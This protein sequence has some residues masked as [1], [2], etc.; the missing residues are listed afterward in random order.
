[1]VD[2]FL[3]LPIDERERQA[4]GITAA[5]VEELVPLTDV[6]D[7][8]LCRRMDSTFTQLPAYYFR[9]SGLILGTNYVYPSTDRNEFARRVFV[10][11]SLGHRLPPYRIAYGPQDLRPATALGALVE[12][13]WTNIT[14]NLDT[15]RLQR[16]TGSGAFAYVG[17]S[18]NGGATGVA[19]TT[20]VAG[21][22][23]RYRLVSFRT[24]SDS[25]FSNEISV[26][27][28]DLGPVTRAITGLLFRDQFDRADGAP[29]A[30]W[31]AESG[32]WTIA[33]NAMQIDI[34]YFAS[35]VMRLASL[36]NRKDFHIQVMSSRSQLGNYAAVYARR[37]GGTLYLADLGASSEQGGKP[38]MYRQTNGG[39]TVLG[40]GTFVSS[41]NTMHRL[42]FSVLGSEQKLWADGALQVSVTD[43]AAANDI[44]G[45]LSFHAYGSGTAGTVR[46]DDLI[47]NASRS[48]TIGGLPVGHRL[49][50]AGLLS[51]RA[52]SGNDVALDLMGIQLP[53]ARIEV[54]D[55][56]DVMVKIFA[57]ADG[58]W[59]G[60]RYSLNGAP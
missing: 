4:L 38:R 19:D 33:G 22:S 11:D 21:T 7:A 29:G 56:D 47:V 17:S 27:L 12:L 40:Y 43:G 30:D 35:A 25:G 18:F 15:Y 57:P 51:P 42:T 50:I 58:V 13:V 31:I 45:N 6:A 55:A 48:V 10:F 8:A 9:A 37:V 16:A 34:P 36:A 49:R 2:A 3:Q 5:R 54:L 1:M 53:A 59:G 26:S 41:A 24:G 20:A 44:A 23:Y 46:F 60:D 39:Y 32:T 14:R 52:T 28:T